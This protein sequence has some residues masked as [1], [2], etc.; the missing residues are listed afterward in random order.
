MLREVLNAKEVEH[1]QLQLVELGTAENQTVERGA[2]VHVAQLLQGSETD[3]LV[4]A[5]HTR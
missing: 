5:T 3:E 1:L 4:I 2:E